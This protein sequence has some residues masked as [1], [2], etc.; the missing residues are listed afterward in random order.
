MFSL[1]SREWIAFTSHRFGVV[2]K[3][4]PRPVLSLPGLAS[5]LFFTPSPGWGN[6]D[7]KPPPRGPWL[8]QLAKG[9]CGSAR[10]SQQPLSEAQPSPSLRKSYRRQYTHPD[11][12]T[13]TLTD[14]EYQIGPWKPPD[15]PLGQTSASGEV[16]TPSRI[17][18]EKQRGGGERR[19]REMGV[20]RSRISISSCS[21]GC[22][23]NHQFPLRMSLGR[24]GGE[25]Q[26]VECKTPFRK[27]EKIWTLLQVLF[28]LSL[29]TGSTFY[30]NIFITL[31]NDFCSGTIQ[32]NV[33]S[34]G[35]CKCAQNMH[36]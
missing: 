33:L 29:L 17:K 31:N 36:H 21:L 18:G 27:P 35:C 6:A 24:L 3:K 4:S 7:G 28:L 30:W 1:A 14:G 16:K 32:L 5:T 9:P 19:N 11:A 26:E 23:P 34:D 15:H 2:F 25:R 8:W 10:L 13:Y 22:L 20:K 12:H